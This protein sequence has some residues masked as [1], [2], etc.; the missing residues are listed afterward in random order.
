MA[1]KPF[2]NEELQQ[3]SE[4]IPGCRYVVEVQANTSAPYGDKFNIFFKYTITAETQTT[5]CLLI[6]FHLDWFPSMNRMMKPVVG[7]AIDGKHAAS[8]ECDARKA[9][10]PTMHHQ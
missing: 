10:Q 1:S 2:Q 6:V 4:Y 7:K 5:S 3:C 8:G 9:M